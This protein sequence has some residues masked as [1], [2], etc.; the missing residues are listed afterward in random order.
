MKVVAINGSVRKNG[1]TSVLLKAALRVLER[2]GIETELISLAGRQ[3]VPCRACFACS[4]KGTCVGSKDAFQEV[5]QKM[6][7]A[8]GI[9]L[10]SPVYAANIYSAMQMLLER[11]AVV[12]DVN[13]GLLQHKAGAAIATAR[14]AGALGAVNVMTDFFLNHE[15][16]VAGSTYWNVAYGQAPG[17]A[18]GDEEGMATMEHLGENLAFLLKK[19]GP[20]S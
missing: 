3:M 2:E 19:L 5:F 17:S 4:G 10:G 15:M 14:R 7:E 11:A 1:N 16:F 13:P 18:A 9:L 6:T 20:T 12:A 8:D